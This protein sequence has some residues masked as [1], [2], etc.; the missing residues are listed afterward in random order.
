MALPLFRTEL[1]DPDRIRAEAQIL[2]ARAEA[3]WEAA[4]RLHEV[5]TKGV[6]DSPSGV[7]FASRVGEVPQTLHRLASTLDETARVI[8]PYADLLAESQRVM[9]DERRAYEKYVKESDRLDAQL[10]GMSPEE[11]EYARVDREWRDAADEREFAKR[12]YQ[13]EGEQATQDEETVARR[14]DDIGQT[15]TDPWG[16]DFFEGL[17]D[18]GQSGAVDNVLTDFVPH[19]RLIALLQFADPIGKLGLRAFYGQGS[20]SGVG[21]ATV[22]TTFNVVKVPM[23]VG[24]K[25]DDAARRTSRATETAAAKARHGD[26]VGASGSGPKRL[27]HTVGTKVKQ[28][29]AGAGV[30]ARLGARDAFDNATGVRLV[31]NMT[32][33]WAAIAGAG[34]VTKGVHVLKYSV[35]AADTVDSTFRSARTTAGTLKPLTDSDQRRRRSATDAHPAR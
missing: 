21:K 2:R 25:V 30:R 19:L 6:W 18:L 33:D 11:P 4:G 26:P 14:L 12:R 1:G 8:E 16:Y 20:Y 27:R 22:Q 34:H 35:A 3:M 5:S 29:S 32:S 24:A 15:S 9:K 28:T 17:S 7:T 13:R 10:A 31:S 23:G